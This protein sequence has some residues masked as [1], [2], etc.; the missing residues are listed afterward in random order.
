MPFPHELVVLQSASF[1]VFPM[2]LWAF[3]PLGG[4]NVSPLTP[5][6]CWAFARPCKLQV[7]EMQRCRLFSLGRFDPALVL[8]GCSGPQVLEA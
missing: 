1:R 2:T 5:K 6:A 4:A 8:S 7:P 3:G